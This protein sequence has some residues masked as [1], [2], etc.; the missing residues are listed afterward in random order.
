MVEAVADV[1][2]FVKFD[3]PDD[4]VLA[5]RTGVQVGALGSLFDVVRG[6]N[7]GATCAASFIAEAIVC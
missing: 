7:G 3:R 6:S 2:G 5:P 1:V 4:E